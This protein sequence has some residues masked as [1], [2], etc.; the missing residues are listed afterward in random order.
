MSAD[1]AADS[2][3]G[4]QPTLGKRH[5]ILDYPQTQQLGQFS[6]FLGQPEALNDTHGPIRSQLRELPLINHSEAQHFLL[7]DQPMRNFP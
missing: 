3:Q 2:A 6:L 7:L 4:L 1:C 5:Q